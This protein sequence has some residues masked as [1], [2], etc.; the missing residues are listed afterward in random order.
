MSKSSRVSVSGMI[1]KGPCKSKL[2]LSRF[3]EWFVSIFE[4]RESPRPLHSTYL[5]SESCFMSQDSTL[6]GSLYAPFQYSSLAS[7][8]KIR[9]WL[10][11]VL[12]VPRSG[13][14][15][16]QIQLHK[17]SENPGISPTDTTR[18]PKLAAVFGSFLLFQHKPR[19]LTRASQLPAPKVQIYSEVLLFD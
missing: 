6:D 3:P 10:L 15:I 17:F 14:S 8:G 2:K 12:L 1:F 11:K 7:I 5:C 13:T 16:S 4:A 18:S 19:L 9:R